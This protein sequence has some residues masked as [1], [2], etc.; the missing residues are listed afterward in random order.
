MISV[1]VMAHPKRE[2]W[3]THLSR[4]LGAP[5]VWDEQNSVWETGRRALLHHDPKATHHLVIQDDALPAD[6]LTAKVTRAAEAHP[7]SPLCFYMTRRREHWIGRGIEIVGNGLL[8][9]PGPIWGVAVANP[10]ERIAALVAFGDRQNYRAYDRRM[11]DYWTSQKVPC[12]YSVPCLVDHR[13]V[14]ENPSIVD[15]RRNG[16]RRAYWFDRHLEPDW[17][18]VLPTDRETLWPSVVLEGPDGRTKRV[19]V[20]QGHWER[21][22]ARGWKVRQP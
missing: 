20:G 19:R 15:P 1:V 16:N 22:L 7:G 2:K 4:T 6:D 9:H 14:A 12:L 13:P 5:I 17:S 3:A 21:Y 18:R 11:M 10:V 8:A